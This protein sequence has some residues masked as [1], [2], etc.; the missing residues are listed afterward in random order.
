LEV[1]PTPGV[2][3]VFDALH[4][5]QY[6]RRI[7]NLDMRSLDEANF[8]TGCVGVAVS[9]VVALL[10][11]VLGTDN[12]SPWLVVV[13]LTL[14]IAS[15]VLALFFW[16]KYNTAKGEIKKTG[17]VIAEELREVVTAQRA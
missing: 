6:C 10:G 1:Q 7:E 3:V 17:S 14:F 8:L 4:V 2:G 12:A 15:T 5:E 11:V 9:M 13:F 16:R